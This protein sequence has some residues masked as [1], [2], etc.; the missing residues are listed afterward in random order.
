MLSPSPDPSN[1]QHRGICQSLVENRKEAEFC[2][3]GDLGGGGGEVGRGLRDTDAESEGTAECRSPVLPGEA[4][5]PFTGVM[6]QLIKLDTSEHRCRVW[7]DSWMQKPVLPGEAPW[8]FTGAMCQLVKPDTSV[9]TLQHMV[10]KRPKQSY[11]PA[12]P[13]QAS[14]EVMTWMLL[15]EGPGQGTSTCGASYNLRGISISAPVQ[16]PEGTRGTGQRSNQDRPSA[17]VAT[18]P[19]QGQGLRPAPGLSPQLKSIPP[20]LLSSVIRS[21]RNLVLY[22]TLPGWPPQSC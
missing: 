20:V 17:R 22:W 16:P 7:R 12:P 21:Y 1:L 4:P 10:E 18:T 11:R 19:K 9:S 14:M 2:D 13:S 3:L 15:A 6:C 8:S 5:W